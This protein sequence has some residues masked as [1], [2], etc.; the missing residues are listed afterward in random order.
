[1]SLVAIARGCHK[2]I[3]VFNT[4]EEAHSPIYAIRAEE[5]TGGKRD[6]INPVIVA[7]NGHHYESIEPMT[8]EDCLR[9]IRLVESYKKEEYPLEKKDINKTYPIKHHN[10]RTQTEPRAGTKDTKVQCQ[11]NP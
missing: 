5:Y 10:R 11:R 2:D 6:N 4:T 3:L 8:N 7:Y 9:S 1:M